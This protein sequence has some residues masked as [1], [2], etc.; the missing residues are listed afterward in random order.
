MNALTHR[1]DDYQQLRKIRLI[2]SWV[3]LIAFLLFIPAFIAALLAPSFWTL[4][5]LPMI[6]T[7]FGG[8]T[9]VRSAAIEKMD[10]ITAERSRQLAIEEEQLD[11]ELAAED[12]I[13]GIGLRV[14]ERS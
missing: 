10:K 8:A 11:R 5:F 4:V 3:R 7:M 1:N 12:R 2:T 9:G 6:A 13:L 14:G